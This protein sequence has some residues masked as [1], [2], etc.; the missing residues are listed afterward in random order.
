MERK[1]DGFHELRMHWPVLMPSLFGIAMVSIHSYSFGVMTIAVQDAFGWPRSEIALGFSICALVTLLA[2]PVVGLAVDRFGARQIALPGIVAYCLSLAMLA[3]ATSDVR[4]WWLLWFLVAITHVFVAPFVWL[5]IVGA[6]FNANRGIA[7]AIALCGTGLCSAIVPRLA[8]G[9]V[10]TWGWRGGY[11]GLALIGFVVAFPLTWFLFRPIGAIRG[12][13][14]IAP[15]ARASYQGIPVRGAYATPE[16]R[17]LAG[18]VGLYALGLSV[19]TTNLVPVLVATGLTMASAASFAGFAGVGT[20]I[21]RLSSGLLL[22]WFDPAQV[23]ASVVLL[24]IVSALLLLIA[25]PSFVLLGLACFLVGL[26]A[27]G[28]YDSVAYLTARH[29]GSEV[30]GAML[31]ALTGV[32]TLFAAMGPVLSNHV[33]DTT[34]SYDIVLWLEIPTCLVVAML[35][36]WLGSGPSRQSAIMIDRD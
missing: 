32:M 5:K 13:G 33:F 4:T 30:F 22:D 10:D 9:L 2:A 18:V 15:V 7:I 12:S 25:N 17:K 8:N 20:I 3:L 14:S 26:S 35:F 21:G 31:G 19:L 34:G 24:P 16:F 28:E 1:S 29:F 23:G 11:V 6:G 27:G 36:L